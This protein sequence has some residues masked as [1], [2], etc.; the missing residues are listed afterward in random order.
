[1]GE[2]GGLASYRSVRLGVRLILMLRE[3]VKSKVHNGLS[4]ML[5]FAIARA[6]GTRQARSG[7][8]DSAKPGKAGGYCQS[9]TF[10]EKEKT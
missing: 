4:A 3:S 6:Y 2:V 9:A 7:A 8:E 5:P 1:M 10:F